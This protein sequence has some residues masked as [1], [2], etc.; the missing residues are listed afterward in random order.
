MSLIMSQSYCPMVCVVISMFGRSITRCH[1]CVWNIYEIYILSDLLLWQSM[2]WPLFRRTRNSPRKR[3][4]K[5]HLP[6]WWCYYGKC[7]SLM[8][9][10]IYSLWYL[11]L[12]YVQWFPV[13]FFL[14]IFIEFSR[15]L[16]TDQA[17]FK[18]TF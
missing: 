8:S 13:V 12:C 7:L 1:I 16:R 6:H 3:L 11:P 9:L 15:S 4:H 5:K 18:L 14:L 10:T 17:H 2:C